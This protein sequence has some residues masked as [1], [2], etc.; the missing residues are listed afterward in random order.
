MQCPTNVKSGRRQ[1][2]RQIKQRAKAEKKKK[3]HDVRGQNRGVMQL[4]KGDGW[5]NT[6]LNQ[7]ERLY[8]GQE[9]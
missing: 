8:E 3:R 6:G 1:G 5:Q 9:M 4:S 7:G 2:R